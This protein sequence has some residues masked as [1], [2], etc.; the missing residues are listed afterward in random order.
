MGSADG[1]LTHDEIEEAVRALAQETEQSESEE[2]GPLPQESDDAEK[3]PLERSGVRV[4]KSSRHGSKF[5]PERKSTLE[6]IAEGARDRAGSDAV[7]H[8][9]RDEVRSPPKPTFE[10]DQEQVEFLQK[11]LKCVSERIEQELQDMA[12]LEEVLLRP[13]GQMM[14]Q[15][16]QANR[17]NIASQALR[18][19][20]LEATEAN[21]RIKTARQKVMP[22][23]RAVHRGHRVLEDIWR[24]P[25]AK[26]I[27][28]ETPQEAFWISQS[29]PSS[30][31]SALCKQVPRK[32]APKEIHTD[33][34]SLRK[35]PTLQERHADLMRDTNN[36]LMGGTHFF[37]QGHAMAKTLPSFPLSERS[38]KSG[39]AGCAMMRK[40]PSKPSS[41]PSSPSSSNA[42]NSNAFAGIRGPKMRRELA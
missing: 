20:V 1:E 16:E 30:P 12:G 7:P 32:S 17:A 4:R 14:S 24:R 19:A 21:R 18:D 9:A 22:S 5:A 42:F 15:Q 35:E 11:N 33:L 38:P 2:W 37:D 13:R 26:T 10:L 27:E 41:L 28:T 40:T 6:P 8:A 29:I 3:G 34:G 23:P 31:A 39:G 36:G 25:N